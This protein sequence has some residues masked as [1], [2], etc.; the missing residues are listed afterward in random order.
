MQGYYERAVKFAVGDKEDIYDTFYPPATQIVYSF[1]IKIINPFF[2]IKLFNVFV[3]IATCFLIYLI[4]K[5]LFNRQAGYI[6]LFIACFNYLFI[7]FTGYLLSETFFAFTLAFMFYCFLKSVIAH[8]Q[9]LRWLYS[10]LAG[11]FIIIAGA[12][13]SSILLFIPLFGLWW[14]LNFKKYKIFSNLAFYM[15]GFLP[16]FIL[17]TLRFHSLT[18]EYGIISTNGGFNFFQGR[19][20]I[21][22]ARFEDK[23]RSMGYLF[24][25]PVAV[26]KNYTYNDSFQ[27]GPYDSK[28]FYHKGIEE[29]KK[30][31]PRTLLYSFENLYDLFLL[32]DVW[33][34]FAIDK[35]FPNVIKL[36]SWLFILLVLIPSFF[37]IIVCSRVVLSG[38]RIILIFPIITI[39]ITSF[40]FYGDPRFRV[41]YDV[42]FIILAGYFYAEAFKKIKNKFNHK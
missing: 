10:F 34:S 26:R 5:E 21:R 1:L 29:M 40:V 9:S 33:P 39:L 17:M 3:N 16:L 28:F 20:H 41:P 12:T 30:D 23:K 13:K 32:P 22:D 6:G 15:A 18:G 14:F 19:S 31:I 27:T 8:K 24:A 4:S 11:L 42:F 2:W 38:V 25:S 35:P 36:A 37:V 7:D